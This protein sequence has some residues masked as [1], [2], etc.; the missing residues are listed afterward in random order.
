MTSFSS[1][2]RFQ[3][4]LSRYM[5]VLLLFFFAVVMLFSCDATEHVFAFTEMYH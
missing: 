4:L 5:V 3:S 1:Y 2:C